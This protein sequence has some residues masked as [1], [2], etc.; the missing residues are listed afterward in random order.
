MV[1]RR[2][3]VAARDSERA[4]DCFPYPIGFKDARRRP[5]ETPE[6]F[7]AETTDEAMQAARW[8]PSVL[9][10]GISRT[11]RRHGD[12]GE[13]RTDGRS[14]ST[15][16]CVLECSVG[17]SDVGA[18]RDVCGGGGGVPRCSAWDGPCFR[19]EWAGGDANLGEV[20]RE[21]GRGGGEAITASALGRVGGVREDARRAALAALLE[22]MGGTPKGSGGLERVSRRGGVWFHRAGFNEAR[23]YAD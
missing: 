4:E 1:E 14:S 22:T 16:T 6:T 15:T 3:R 23:S 17:M 10:D 2:R 21:R 12:D 7:G 18:R 19:V 20:C 11:K 8:R 9:V 5:R 13:D